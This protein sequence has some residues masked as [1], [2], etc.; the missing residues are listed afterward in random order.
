MNPGGM[1]SALTVRLIA[2]VVVLALVLLPALFMPMMFGGMMGGWN[3]SN[4]SG[5]GGN[6]WWGW[7][8]RLLLWVLLISGGVAFVAWA[9]RPSRAGP[10]GGGAGS[11]PNEPLEILRQRY[12]RGEIT[13]EQFEQMRR[14]LTTD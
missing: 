13:S 2:L 11:L 7:L 1:R 9:V 5:W 8:L 3:P 6:M 12:A 4:W 10:S 14:D